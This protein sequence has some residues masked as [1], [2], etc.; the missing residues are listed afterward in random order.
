M[1]FRRSSAYIRGVR[2]LFKAAGYRVHLR[3]GQKPDDD[4]ALMSRATYFV[5]GGG[6]FS[7]R[8]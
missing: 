7:I 5:Q 3:L 6:G 8:L 2:R 4:F 1:G